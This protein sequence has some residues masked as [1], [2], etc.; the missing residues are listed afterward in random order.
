MI[1]ILPIHTGGTIASTKTKHGTKP[2]LQFNSI[3]SKVDKKILKDIKIQ[4]EITPFGKSG[5]DS[6]NLD[7]NHIKK[8]YKI[9]KKNYK[10]YDA[11]LIT[12]GTDTLSYTSS[13]LYYM[14]K[15]IK[16]PLILT[17]SQK[18]INEK[19]SDVISNLTTAI[20]ACKSQ[21]SGVWVAFDN[22]IFYGNSIT[23]V[24][25]TSLSAF[26]SPNK[27][28]LSIN[29]FLNK[30][31]INNKKEKFNKKLSK[32][33]GIYYLTPTSSPSEIKH[34]LKNKFETII[35]LVY[36]LGGHKK[37]IFEEFTKSNKKIIAKSTCIYGKTD[38]NF[39]EVGK[40]AKNSGIKASKNLSLEALFAKESL[41]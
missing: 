40:N 17:A 5:I 24:D 16:K 22:Q 26:D 34:Y 36:G 21:N 18:T 14:F 27:N 37:E 8:L 35:I 33:V 31:I 4:K 7:L 3:L 12:H 20:K 28:S 30:K 38:L 1:K 9:I 13:F 25:S 19:N 39:Y 10:K 15:N 2:T 23:K 11:F 29:Q 6:S 41:K 32:K